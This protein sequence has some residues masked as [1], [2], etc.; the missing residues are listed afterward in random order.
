MRISDWSSD[1]CSS[2]LHG[3]GALPR[4][5]LIFVRPAAIIGHRAAVE[6]ALGFLGLPVG[7]VDEDDDG[8]P[9]HV[10]PGIVVPALFRGVDA[11]TDKDDVAVLDRGLRRHAIA[12]RDIILGLL[13]DR[14]SVVLGKSVSVS[15]VPG[16]RRNI[17]K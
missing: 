2:D 9:L 4:G 15:V 17:K 13:R 3:G 14:N 11:V 10:E 7:I 6:F 8:L 12:E 16:G 1:V 5:F